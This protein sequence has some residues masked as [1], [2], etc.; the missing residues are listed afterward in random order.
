[1]K[2]STRKNRTGIQAWAI[3]GAA[4]LILAGCSTVAEDSEVAELTE[5]TVA[6]PGQ[7]GIA[8]YPVTVADHLGYFEEEGLDVTVESLDGSAAVLQA[9]QAD[10]AD[11]GIPG[12]GP[13]FSSLLGGGDA[14]YIYNLYPRGFFSIAG[15]AGQVK[16]IDDLR[17]ATIG[18]STANGGEVAWARA[19]LQEAGLAPDEYE[20]ATVGSEGIAVSSF[21]RGDIQAYAASMTGVA[22]L[23]VRG[24]DLVNLTPESAQL[25]GNGIAASGAILEK[26]PETVEAFLRAV[27]RAQLHGFDNA[28]DVL[29]AGAEYNEQEAEDPEYATAI[30]DAVIELMKPNDAQ[31]GPGYFTDQAVAAWH[32]VLVETGDIE[33]PLADPSV[34]YTNEFV[35]KASDG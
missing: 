1:M 2:L 12:A 9:M 18:V 8:Y 14:A 13:L 3:A 5:I 19:V 10:R 31:E 24:V 23:D 27:A 22:T 34:V 33:A 29:E 35:S 20:F 15:D 6:V 7:S 21:E 16:S 4:V 17:G 11:F 32:A 30:Y 26:S 28:E 25:F